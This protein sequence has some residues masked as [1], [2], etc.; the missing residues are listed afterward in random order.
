MD[1]VSDAR[2]MPHL[3]MKMH[4]EEEARGGEAIETRNDE[5][6]T[7]PLRELTRG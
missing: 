1:I 4:M 5:H 3:N 6:E 7:H 2:I